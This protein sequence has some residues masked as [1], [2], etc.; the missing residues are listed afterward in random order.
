MTRE[1]SE[2]SAQFYRAKLA[3]SDFPKP[4]VVQIENQQHCSIPTSPK[5]WLGIG[6]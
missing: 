2:I 6:R 4:E 3:E 1:S 5:L